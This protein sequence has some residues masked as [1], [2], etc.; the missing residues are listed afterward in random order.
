M[1]SMK[2]STSGEVTRTHQKS[3]P[4]TGVTLHLAEMQ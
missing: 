2:M 1:N 4:H 3:A